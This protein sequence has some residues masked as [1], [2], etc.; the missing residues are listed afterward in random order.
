MG[1]WNEGTN[2][3]KSLDGRIWNQ[4]S[5]PTNGVAIASGAGVLVVASRDGKLYR[6]ENGSDWETIVTGA[7]SYSTVA[8]AGGMFLAGAYDEIWRST[9]GREWSRAAAPIRSV[10]TI[11]HADGRF[12]AAGSN[13]MASSGDG[14][15]WV[16]K[17]VYLGFVVGLAFGNGRWVIRN[18]LG[19]T[20][21]S[22]DGVEWKDETQLTGIIRDLLLWNGLVI[23]AR[24]SIAVFPNL[25]TVSNVY[26]GNGGRFSLAH[27]E[28]VVV[29][30]SETGA[31]AFSTNGV[32]WS[33]GTGRRMSAAAYGNAI[34]VGICDRS[35][36]SRVQKSGDGMVWTDA[37]FPVADRSLRSV[38]G[39]EVCRLRKAG[40]S[41]QST[42]E[43]LEPKSQCDE[44][45]LRVPRNG[46][47]CDGTMGASTSPTE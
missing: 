47:L 12:V 26:I 8:Y 32:N 39:R 24:G 33:A 4:I 10:L 43:S 2:L 3:I 30:V 7:S 46:C 6:S 21:T 25:T 34:F 42:D 31:P 13:G 11:V 17:K 20:Y 27:N 35:D 9:D 16:A 38:L 15:E 1:T 36:I 22:A 5:G 29:S 41:S 28:S 14:V 37:P 40:P 18:E 23:G 19:G 45:I 44:D